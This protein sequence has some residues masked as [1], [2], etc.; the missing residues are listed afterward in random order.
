MLDALQNIIPVVFADFRTDTSKV[1]WQLYAYQRN[2]ETA[3]S[4]IMAP[5]IR[6]QTIL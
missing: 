4:E 3:N 5:E 2:Q 1:D 6:E